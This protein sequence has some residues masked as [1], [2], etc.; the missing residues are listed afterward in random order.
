[1]KEKPNSSARDLVYYILRG[2][3]AVVAICAIFASLKDSF[4]QPSK[5]PLQS[6]VQAEMRSIQV[7]IE[8]YYVDHA[9]Y[10]AWNTGRSSAHKD[11]VNNPVY[12]LVPTFINRTEQRPEIHT[13]TTPVAYMS[14]LYTDPY[15]PAKGAGYAYWAGGCK[16]GWI[17][18]SPGPDGN[19]EI[20]PWEDYQTSS[21]RPSTS[22]I[23][24]T[25]D[26]TNGAKSPGDLWYTKN[27][28]YTRDRQPIID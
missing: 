7:A 5:R 14:S 28:P 3:V 18:Y 23:A 21:V 9:A 25:Y 20:V 17:V 12:L 6:R 11:F 15:A 26:P 2:L 19:Y 10:P 27:W 13:L 8:C 24:K 16:T 1:M 22:L 4:I